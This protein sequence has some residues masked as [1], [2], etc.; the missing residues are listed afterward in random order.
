MNNKRNV[1][2]IVNPSRSLLNEGLISV[3]TKI[4]K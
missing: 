2:L 4:N 3:I 1:L